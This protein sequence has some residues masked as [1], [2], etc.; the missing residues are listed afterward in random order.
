MIQTPVDLGRITRN[1]DV[2]RS[3]GVSELATMGVAVV[4]RRDSVLAKRVLL[5]RLPVMN[6]VTPARMIGSDKT[7]RD[8][9][10]H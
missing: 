10:S 3:R 1:Q 7:R 2:C 4:P 8:A 6:R 5:K 9:M